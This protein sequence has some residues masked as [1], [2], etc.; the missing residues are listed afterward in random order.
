MVVAAACSLLNPSTPMLQITVEMDESSFGSSVC[1]RGRLLAVG[2]PLSNEHDV[3]LDDIDS[4]GALMVYQGSA[5]CPAGSGILGMLESVL[6]SWLRYPRHVRRCSRQLAQVS[7]A[8]TS[9]NRTGEER[10]S[11]GSEEHG[12]DDGDDR[13]WGLGVGVRARRRCRRRRM[14]VRHACRW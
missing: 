9:D 10:G 14:S 1:L 5:A 2:A 7:K 8:A 3:W 11:G 4:P 6:G 13:G 12:N